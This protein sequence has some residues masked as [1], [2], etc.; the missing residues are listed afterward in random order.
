MHKVLGTCQFL[1]G[2]GMDISAARVANHMQSDANNLVAIASTNRFPEQRETIHMIQML[3][4]ESCSGQ[5]EDLAHVS[6]ADCLSD[7]LTKSSAKSDALYKAV[8]TGILPNLDM[9]PLFKSLLKHKVYLSRWLQSI[10]GP[11]APFVSFFG[12]I[13]LST[14]C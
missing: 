1:L 2:L 9:H 11:Q 5:I 14:T 13:P 8:S 7:C 4:K 12:D 6:S 3:R 10:V